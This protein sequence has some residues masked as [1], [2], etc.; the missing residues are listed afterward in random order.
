MSAVT[1][2]PTT[3]TLRIKAHKTTVLLH[4]DPLSTFSNIKAL[5]L[6][7]LKETSL[8]HAG[9]GLPV[10]LPDSPSEIQLGKP[11][12]KHD[13]QAGFVLGDWEL[14]DA[15]K[16]GANGKKKEESTLAAPSNIGQCP[17]GAGLKDG[18]VLVARW[19]RD[20]TGWSG[21]PE[22]DEEDELV[23]EEPSMWGVK[24]ASYEDSYGV[25]NEGD[26]GGGTNPHDE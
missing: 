5:F 14:K 24:I 21:P 16:D 4:V 11:V 25:E 2:S 3:W 15:K 12:D 19:K 18:A 10:S 1:P 13:P 9:T 26:V 8:K 7:A 17:K 23:Q 6:A 22:G 20:G